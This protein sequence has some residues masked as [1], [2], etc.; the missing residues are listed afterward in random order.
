[1]S[2]EDAM[3]KNDPTLVW[4]AVLGGVVMFGA[5]C[6]AIGSSSV[7]VAQR[8]IDDRRDRTAREREE[9]AAAEAAGHAA[10]LEPL[11]LSPDGTVEEPIIGVVEKR[12]S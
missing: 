5:L 9:D 10:A 6:R 11:A 4:M 7:S 8:L 2:D 12:G 1:M 3:W